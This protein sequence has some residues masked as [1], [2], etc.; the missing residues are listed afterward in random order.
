MAE[1]KFDTIETERVVIDTEKVVVLR[2]TE[3]E[4][5]YLRALTGAV[6]SGAG[7]N[8]SI[9]QALGAAGIYSQWGPMGRMTVSRSDESDW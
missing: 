7:P 2:M 6:P 8:R 4:A 9:Y 5:R 1:V 3:T